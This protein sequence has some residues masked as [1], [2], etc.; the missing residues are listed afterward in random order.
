MMKFL[1]TGVLLGGLLVAL[2]GVG[3]AD[4]LTVLVSASLDSGGPFLELKCALTNLALTIINAKISIIDSDGK[5][6]EP[7]LTGSAYCSD[8]TDTNVANCKIPP[9]AIG[10]VNCA[11]GRND[12]CKAV[13]NAPP[14]AV[15]GSLAEQLDLPSFVI[16]TAVV[17]TFGALDLHQVSP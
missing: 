16:G 13:T 8:P 4:G 6:C 5:L 3:Q 11:N 15:L 14:G 7:D 17:A 9:G 1:S 12:Y 2:T 10:W